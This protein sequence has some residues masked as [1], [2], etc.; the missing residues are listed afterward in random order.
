MIEKVSGTTLDVFLKTRI[1]DPLDMRDTS[2]FL[3]AEKRTRL[4]AVYS[5]SNGA[6]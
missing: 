5:S 3:P 1:L 4:A 2:F 6:R